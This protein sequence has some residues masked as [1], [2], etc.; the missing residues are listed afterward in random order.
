MEKITDLNQYLKNKND[1]TT[2]Y[3]LTACMIQTLED[4]TQEINTTVYA[5]TKIYP[6][7]EERDKLLKETAKQFGNDKLY[8]LRELL[9]QHSKNL[10]DIADFL[11]KFIEDPKP[12][13]VGKMDMDRRNLAN[14]YASTHKTIFER[15]VNT[16]LKMLD[17]AVEAD[18]E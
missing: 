15:N 6:N 9:N 16:A 5:W 3:V 2:Q 10:T 17:E 18:P 1:K 4:I 13:E 12:N 14:E 7:P 8:N 11:S